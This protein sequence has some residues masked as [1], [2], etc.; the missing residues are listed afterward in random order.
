[1]MSKLSIGQVFVPL[2]ALSFSVSV[3]AEPP[4][5]ARLVDIKSADATIL[6]GS[7]FAAAKPGPGILLFHQSNRTRTSWDDLARKLAEAGI[8]VL[9]I[10]SRGHGE[11]GGKEGRRNVR[12]VDEDA[13][14]QFLTAQPGVNRDIIGLGGA[15]VIGVE[16]ATELAHRCSRQVKSLVLI[17]GEALRP[18]VEFL[19]EAWQLAGLYVVA[20]DDEYR[21]IQ[22]AMQLLYTSAASPAKRLIH[23]SAP[24]PAP[25]LWYE[26]VDIGKVPATGGHGTD[27]FKPHP[28]LAAIVVQWFVTTLLKTPGHAPA[29]PVAAGPILNNVAFEGG[30]ARAEQRLREARASDPAAQLWPEITMTTIAESLLADGHAEEALEVMKLNL[31]A[32]PDSADAEANLADAYVAA[33]DK[34]LARQHAEKALSILQDDGKPASSWT[35]TEQYR[36]EIRK[37][38]EKILTQLNSNS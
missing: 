35:N 15:G 25:W 20:D 28:E 16:N 23:Y 13:A 6:K 27:L 3:F 30:A 1:M 18:E 31:L 9:T 32:Y 22:E 10:D 24:E 5:N 36:G 7:Y 14:L 29:D 8:N 37:E 33:G 21:P 12:V 4:K 2:L 17:S 38:A 11:T 26:P 19:H 34:E